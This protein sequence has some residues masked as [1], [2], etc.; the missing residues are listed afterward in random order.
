MNRALILIAALLL[1][2]CTASIS[3]LPQGV[4][5]SYDVEGW[6]DR[7]GGG[8]GGG[9]GTGPRGPVGPAGPTGPAGPPGSGGGPPAFLVRTPAAVAATIESG[10]VG[11]DGGYGSWTTIA[12]S[13]STVITTAN[14]RA[15]IVTVEGEFN[16]VSQGSLSGGGN[17]GYF[18]V[19]LAKGADSRDLG[20]SASTA[21]GPR[22]LPTN[23]SN[24]ASGFSLQSYT[25]HGKVS[26]RETAAAGDVFHMQARLV[27]QTVTSSTLGGTDTTYSVSCATT[28][29]S[30]TVSRD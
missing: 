5:G 26:G 3:I 28:A 17:R 20:F 9:G 29:N 2:G 19:R 11:V 16:C 21:Y 4:Q 14:N 24:T 15:G 10:T 18:Q 13:P 6:S 7:R 27:G 1:G 23:P 12:S 30:I 22:N 8:S 25:V